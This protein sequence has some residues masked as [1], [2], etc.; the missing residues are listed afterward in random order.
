MSSVPRADY[1]ARLDF[2]AIQRL[3][4]MS[5][6]VL[7]GIQLRAAAHDEQR[8]PLDIRRKRC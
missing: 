1:L 3:A 4:V 5:A 7:Y 2:R 8:E 6:T